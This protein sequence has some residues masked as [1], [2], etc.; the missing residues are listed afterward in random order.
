MHTYM[1]AYMY[2]CVYMYVYVYV[3]VYVYVYVYVDVYL[4]SCMGDKSVYIC[5]YY[6][7]T[8]YKI[9]RDI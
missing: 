8:S 1:H 2:V 9:S 7:Y 5:I 3:C 4:Y 6:T